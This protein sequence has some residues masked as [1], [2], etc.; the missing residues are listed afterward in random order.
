MSSRSAGATVHDGSM[1]GWRVRTISV[2]WRSVWL[3]VM[4]STVVRGVGARAD[5][6]MVGGE[7]GVEVVGELHARADQHDQVVAHALE[8]GDQVRGQHDAQLVLGDGLHQAL[9]ELAPVERIEA[10]DRLVEQQQL[11][12]LGEPERERELR[13]LPAGELPAFCAGSSPSRAIR[14]VRERVVPA[15]VQ[16]RAEPQVVLDAEAA[17]GRRVLGDEADL[18]ALLRAG[19]GAPAE[20][21][22]RARGRRSMPAA[23]FSSV[24]LPAPLGPTS[25]TTR[26]AGTSSVQSASAGAAPVALGQAGGL[27]ARRSCYVRP[28]G[29]AEG[30]GEERLDALVVEAR[31]GGPAQPALELL[32]S[33]P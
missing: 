4:T 22:D 31:P 10:G 9:E 16:P 21:L 33:G 20:H 17:V 23:R 15:R 11:G 19:R 24:L 7:H 5:E 27:E 6:A 30:G 29:G 8:V 1:I 13:A 32:R 12:A 2:L 3:A 28:G 14:R 26:P 18:G 25:P